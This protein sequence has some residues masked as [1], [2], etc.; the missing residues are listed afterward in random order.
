M[1]DPPSPADEDVVHE[2]TPVAYHLT[3]LDGHGGMKKY[4]REFLPF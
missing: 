4:H 2:A 3:M 1:D